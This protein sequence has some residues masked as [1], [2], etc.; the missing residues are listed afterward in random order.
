MT[1]L[2]VISYIVNAAVFAYA[3]TR[4]GSA[5]LAADRNRSFW[6]VLLAILGFMGVLGIA[7][8]VAFLVGV[9]PRMHAAAGPP[10]SQ[11]PNVRANPFTKN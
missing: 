5:W 4:P 2:V 7:A 1:A 9:L 8:D 11:D 3:V 10:P 6:L